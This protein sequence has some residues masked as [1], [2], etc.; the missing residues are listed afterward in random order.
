[1]STT[2]GATRGTEATTTWVDDHF[3]A[4]DV[5]LDFANTV[6]RRTPELGADLLVDA[7][8]LETWLDRTRLLPSAGPGRTFTDPTAALQTARSLRGLLWTVLHALEHDQTIPVDTF[9]GLLDLARRDL[10]RTS[11]HADGSIA[12]LCADGAFTALALGATRLVLDPPPQGVRSCDR[13]GWFFIDSSRSRR[14]RWC[15][16]KTCGNQAKAARYR[17]A[18]S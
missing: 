3:I 17:T 14:R 8:S 16:M 11:V 4:G 5:V 15:S 1:M 10:A 12:S 18:H 9:A 2:G 6:Y 7:E 13:C